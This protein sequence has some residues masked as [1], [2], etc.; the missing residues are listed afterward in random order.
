MSLKI[1][2]VFEKEPVMAFYDDV[3]GIL[4]YYDTVYTAA[5]LTYQP[6]PKTR[7]VKIKMIFN[8]SDIARIEVEKFYKKD[9][10][11]VVFMSMY[12]NNVLIEKGNG[13][14]VG[15]DRFD[16][17]VNQ[18]EKFN[19]IRFIVFTIFFIVSVI[20]LFC[21]STLGLLFSKI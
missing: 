18:D 1:E 15:N 4:F 11:I 14:R 2:K 7:A 9:C 5:E 17:L 21:L 20:F 10:K 19:S 12:Y 8:I 13:V 6:L 3:T 16:S